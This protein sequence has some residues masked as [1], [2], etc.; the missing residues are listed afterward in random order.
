MKKNE[1]TNLCRNVQKTLFWTDA[2]PKVQKLAAKKDNFKFLD[3][4]EL[5]DAISK[6]KKFDSD[7]LWD[8]SYVGIARHESIC[9]VS[10]ELYGFICKIKNLY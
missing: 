3:N 10:S 6:I 5:N 2:T 1:I 8:R 4:T 9:A 7:L